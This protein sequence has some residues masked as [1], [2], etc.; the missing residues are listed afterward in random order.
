MKKPELRVSY[1]NKELEK[2]LKKMNEKEREKRELKEK[3]LKFLKHPKPSNQL[4]LKE[5]V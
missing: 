5:K 3:I 1:R 4:N 2:E